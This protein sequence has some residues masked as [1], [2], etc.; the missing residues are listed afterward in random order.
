MQVTS[1]NHNLETALRL[2]EAGLYVFPC[3]PNKRPVPGFQWKQ[4]ASNDTGEIEAMWRHYGG[5]PMPALHLG[6][7]GLVVIDIDRHQLDGVAAFD[8]LLDQYGGLPMCPAVETPNNGYHLYFKQPSGRAP[9]G[10]ISGDLPAGV[11][12]RGAGGYTIAPGAVRED[13]TFYGIAAG[14]PDLVEAYASRTI[15]EIPGWIVELIDAPRHIEPLRDPSVVAEPISDYRARAWGVAALE[16][17]AVKLAATG[18]GARNNVLNSV[19]YTLAGKSASGC[20]SEGEV[21]N[22]LSAACICN[23]LPHVA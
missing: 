16:G 21:F 22:A 8:M 7:C 6:P 13:G 2:A 15:P 5:D 19:T 17:E 4:W 20:L 9:L 1:M 11:D 10:N 12:I 23:W 3:G 18:V 14:W